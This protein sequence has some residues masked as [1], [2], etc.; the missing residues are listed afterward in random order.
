MV[1]WQSPAPL[2][3]NRGGPGDGA[4]FSQGHRPSVKSMA[5]SQVRDTVGKPICRSG[6]GLVIA[7]QIYGRG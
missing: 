7:E 3:W 1:A 4:R 5:M 6:S 2:Q